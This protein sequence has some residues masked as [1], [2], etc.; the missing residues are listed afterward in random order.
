MSR[1]VPP[2]DPLGEELDHHLAQLREE[3]LARGDT[4]E[5][6]ERLARAKL[7]NRTTIHESV[8]ELQPFGGAATRYFRFAARTLFRDKSVYF[9]AV[10]I[11]ALGMAMSMA[12]FSLTDAVL[13]RPLPFPKQ[14]DLFVIW[15]ADPL[16]GSH[17]EEL[18][19]PELGD[20]QQNI[21]SFAHAAVMPT[22]LY[23]Y[24]R[25]L[26]LPGAEPVQIESTPVS[27]DY[28]RVLG[29]TPALGRDF[30]AG[31]EHPG[32]APVVI[33][34]DCVW[35][36]HLGADPKIVGRMIRLNGSGH[37]VIGVLPPGAEFPR[38]AGLWIPLGVDERIVT[39]RGMT[40]LQAIARVKPGTAPEPISGEVK[41]LFHRLAQEHPDVYSRSQQAVVTPLTEYWVGSARLH[42]WILLAASLLL[43]LASNISAA[44]LLLS[45][46]LSRRTEIATRL[47]IGA[48]RNQILAQLAAE[49][50]LV[51]L[52]ASG[53][54]LVLAEGLIRLLVRWAP[55]DIPRLA[56][57]SVDWDSFG[58]AA[59][60]AALAALACTVIPGWAATRLP[61]E[62]AIREGSGRSSHSRHGNRTRN[63]FILAQAAVTVVLLAM[64]ALLGT[65]YYALLTADTGFANRD[66]VSLNLQMRGPGTLSGVDPQA[67]KAFYTRLLDRLRAAPGVSSAAAVLLRP[68]EGNIGWDV[69]YEFESEAG[70]RE[71]R[72]LPKANYEVVTPGYF[73][74][75]GTPLLEGRDF[76]DHDTE[77]T[78][79]VVII[80]EPL[81]DRIRATGHNPIGHRLR[82]GIGP[83]RWSTVV[84]IT[85]PA[86]YRN[87]TQPGADLFVPCRQ[88]APPTNYVVIRGSRPVQELVS[89]VRRTLAEFDPSQAAGRVA[90]L[91]ELLDANTARHGF[92]MIVLTCFGICAAILAAT[93]IYSVVAGAMAARRR[94]IA[95]RI[96][97]GAERSCL[98]RELV[99]R[100][101]AFSLLGQLLGI[102]CVVSLG[103]GVS[104][105]LYGVKVTNP[106]LLTAVVALL[107]LLSFAAA[108]RPAWT[109]A[110]SDPKSSLR[111]D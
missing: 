62:S 19:Y 49:G 70:S 16:A 105:L 23:G 58:F 68:L 107:F 38:G 42:L 15:K 78:E 109:V 1:P 41:A 60:L 14:N 29:V 110:G 73:K 93:G 12:M 96:A 2:S 83:A 88:A 24:A 45:R 28:F 13:L 65:S 47:A 72:V 100:P 52:L 81:A 91:G 55:P 87:V 79:P 3:R 5:E 95:I 103:A 75:V 108:W 4:P 97:L 48:G 11:L 40:F 54:G 106:R 34:S 86:R 30:T 89:L 74:T 57:A 99:A 31:D 76:T 84:G 20:L 36:T 98:V 101:L 104:D 64:A 39:R 66:A 32:A 50:A 53:A 18:A 35:R 21:R 102:L 80:S 94:E 44:N 37:T 9:V 51:A 6:A 77:E 69:S 7:G 85:A 17:I 43:L 67:R 59:A 10:G 8:F 63:L 90:T 61:L 92:N 46:T 71:S 111:A 26:Q 22:S 27:H 25:V 82:L 33:L 56:S